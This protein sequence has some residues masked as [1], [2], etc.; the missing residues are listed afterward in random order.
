MS[1]MVL[2]VLFLLI[3]FCVGFYLGYGNA[4]ERVVYRPPS[5]SSGYSGPSARIE[6]IKD[7]NSVSKSALDL[8]VSDAKKSSYNAGYTEGK[9]AGQEEGK[10]VGMEEGYDSGYVQGTEYGKSLILDQ[11]DLRVQEAEKTDKNIPLFT[12]K[13][14]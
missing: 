2:S 9:K 12:V 14:K 13:R 7:P 11:I 1:K 4:P 5:E 6:Y 10:K 8:A 3:A